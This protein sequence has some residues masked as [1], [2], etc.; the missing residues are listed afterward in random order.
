MAPHKWGA[1]SG[2]RLRPAFR[3]ERLAQSA[4]YGAGRRSYLDRGSRARDA[5]IVRSVL[6]P[7]SMKLLGERNWYFPSWLSWV[8]DVH[9]EGHATA[10]PSEP[11]A[12]K[13]PENPA[14][15]PA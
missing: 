3:A 6:V 5:R 1:G 15:A 4:T 13:P 8:P 7:A 11:S 10:E 2:P 12:V 14:P 9:V